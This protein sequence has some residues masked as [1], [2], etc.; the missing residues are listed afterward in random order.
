VPWEVQCWSC[1]LLSVLWVTTTG[2]QA[3]LA[4]CA[5]CSLRLE[6]NPFPSRGVTSCGSELGFLNWEIMVGFGGKESRGREKL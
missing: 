5:L 4:Q 3:S 6:E 1:V 2:V